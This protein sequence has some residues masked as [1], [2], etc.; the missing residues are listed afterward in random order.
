MTSEYQSFFAYTSFVF[1]ALDHQLGSRPS[2]VDSETG[3][4]A[5][6]GTIRSGSISISSKLQSE[7]IQNGLPFG[8]MS[9]YC[10]WEIFTSS[11]HRHLTPYNYTVYIL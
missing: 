5:G 4:S 8:N 11:S 2:A 1:S 10:F 3:G 6:T 7:L 9:I